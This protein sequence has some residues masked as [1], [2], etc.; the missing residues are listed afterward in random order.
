MFRSAPRASPLQD[1][2]ERRDR[3]LHV[4]DAD[5]SAR[6]RRAVAPPC[7]TRELDRDADACVCEDFAQTSHEEVTACLEAAAGLGAGVTP[8]PQRR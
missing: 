4:E 2:I 8:L 7:W 1:A 5:A 3:Q 6:T